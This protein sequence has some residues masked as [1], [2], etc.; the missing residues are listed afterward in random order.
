MTED[1]PFN[2]VSK[3]GQVRAKITNRLLEEMAKGNLQATIAR[4]ADF[5]GFSAKTSVLEIM[6]FKNFA[7]NKK[8]NWFCSLDFK[9]SFTFTADAAKA[10]AILG[11]S[12]KAYGETWHLPTASNPPTGKE[13]IELIAGEMSKESRA[14]LV[15]KG[16]T[17]ILGLFS[18]DMNELGE[19]LYQ[20]DRDYVFDSSKFEKSFDF[21]PTNYSAGVK[22]VALEYL[23]PDQS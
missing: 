8:A 1:T 12:E 17:R 9:H 16:L 10:T 11:N 4:S 19:M 15:G 2:P 5:Y 23:A 18:K 7:E 20:Y 3:K 14:Q 6:V 13:W 22:Q 21:K